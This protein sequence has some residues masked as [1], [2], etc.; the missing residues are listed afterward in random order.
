MNCIASF[1]LSFRRSFTFKILSLTERCG[2]PSPMAHNLLRQIF[3][4]QIFLL[5]FRQC[6]ISRLQRFLHPLHVTKSNDRTTNPFMQKPRHRNMAHSPTLLFS[7][8][9]HPA[10]DLPIS[11][12]QRRTPSRSCCGTANTQRTRKVALRK[13]TPLTDNVSPV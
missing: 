5:L 7:Q 11:F 12:S 3:L 2:S 6:F 9:F 13:G 8:L 10:N 4:L 1:S